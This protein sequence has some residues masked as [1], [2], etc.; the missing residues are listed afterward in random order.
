MP[1]VELVKIEPPRKVNQGQPDN[2]DPNPLNRQ[3]LWLFFKPSL[4]ERIFFFRR[5]ITLSVDTSGDTQEIVLE[6]SEYERVQAAAE[7]SPIIS[8]HL[9]QINL[10]SPKKAEIRNG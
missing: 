10:S 3:M 2:F 9:T 6:P 8:K 1:R 7:Y 4:I 5:P